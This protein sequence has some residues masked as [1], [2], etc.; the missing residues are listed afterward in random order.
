VQET[1]LGRY[2]ARVVASDKQHLTLRLRDADHDKTKVL[3]FQQSYPAEYQLA[4][5]MPAA[6][7]ALPQADAQN[8]ARD[9]PMLRGRNSVV[10]FFYFAALCCLVGSVLLRRI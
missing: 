10:H 9:L 8:L 1:G 3:C 4:Q 2:H 7:A 6:V 5:E